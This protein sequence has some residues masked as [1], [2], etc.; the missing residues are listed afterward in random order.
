MTTETNIVEITPEINEDAEKFKNEANEF[1]KSKV[2]KDVFFLIEM[3]HI[4]LF[5]LYTTRAM[6]LQS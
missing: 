5:P 4:F 2:L 3:L 1:F 6:N